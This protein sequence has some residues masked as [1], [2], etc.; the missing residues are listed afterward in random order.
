MWG[1]AGVQTGHVVSNPTAAK[2]SG[3]REHSGCRVRLRGDG[4]GRD[5]LRGGGQADRHRE[6]GGRNVVQG[7]KPEDW[8]GGHL[9][10]KLRPLSVTLF[11]LFYF[12][13]FNG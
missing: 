10:S 3:E 1:A 5:Q 4:G 13:W 12:D 9:P 11:E 7:S 6:A 8:P 2:Q